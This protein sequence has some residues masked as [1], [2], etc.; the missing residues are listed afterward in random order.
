MREYDAKHVRKPT[1]CG[2]ARFILL[3]G[4]SSMPSFTADSLRTVGNELFQA[5]GCSEDDART[6]AEHLV[7]SNLFGHDSHG[8]IRMY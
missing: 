7:E 2:A 8:T 1:V 6:I 3:Y 4:K 5:A